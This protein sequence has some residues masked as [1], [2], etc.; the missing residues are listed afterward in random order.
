MFDASSFHYNIIVTNDIIS[1]C[2][3]RLIRVL[4]SVGELSC[5][6]FIVGGSLTRLGMQFIIIYHIV[7]K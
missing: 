5:D 2:D 4:M 3:N 6:P 7:T 1:L